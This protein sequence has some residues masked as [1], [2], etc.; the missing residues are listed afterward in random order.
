M[1]L[2]GCLRSWRTPLG[3]LRASAGRTRPLPEPP[4]LASLP[5]TL[6]CRPLCCPLLGGRLRPVLSSRTVCVQVRLVTLVGQVVF[7]WQNQLSRLSKDCRSFSASCRWRLPRFPADAR[8]LPPGSRAGSAAARPSA[9]RG[10]RAP[11]QAARRFPGRDAELRLRSEAGTSAGRTQGGCGAHSRHRR[12]RRP[13]SPPL[14]AVRRTEEPRGAA[15][16]SCPAA[17]A[18]P[19]ARH[20]P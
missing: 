10:R 17:L 8:A 9:A 1:F 20:E 12:G 6:R 19:A 3:T 18:S 13:G 15:R 16:P 14:P 4:R 5:G 11:A 2:A 7:P